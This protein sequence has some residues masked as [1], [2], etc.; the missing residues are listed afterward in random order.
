[1][2]ALAA[3][4]TLFLGASA[5]SA[6]AASISLAVSADPSEEQAFTITA[7]GTADASSYVYL[8]IRPAGGAPCAA[9]AGTET[10]GTGLLSTLVPAGAFAVPTTHTS[11]SPSDY[12]LCAYLGSS[13]TTA[14]ATSKA[15]TVRPNRATLTI[16]APAMAIPDQPVVLTFQGSTE[17]GRELF[18]TIKPVGATSCGS[19]HST[20]VGGQDIFSYQPIQGTYSV[21]ESRT[22]KAGGYLICAWVQEGS[23]DLGPDAVA[24]AS[25]SV[26][27]P[28]G[29]GDGVP[30]ATDR[31]PAQAAPGVASGCPPRVTPAAFTATVTPLRDRRAPY[32][33]GFSG[34]LTPPAGLSGPNVCKGNVSVQIKRGTKTLST[35]RRGVRKDCTWIS[36][37][38]FANRSRI[39]RIGRL[40]VLVRFLGNDV[41]S[42][43]GPTALTI[44]AG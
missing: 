1:M 7:S 6:Q 42:P 30:D 21:P 15:I 27:P 31:C 17:V 11:Q 44:R 10:G 33:F 25:I 14:A 38:G 24:T 18:A 22:L 37:I 35:R 8:F 2:I 34:R 36:N 4:L 19:A 39:G 9:T 5:A 20:D 23:T 28:D 16:S 13:S 40:K 43:R 12:L 41:L 32:T 26:P 3:A 29:D